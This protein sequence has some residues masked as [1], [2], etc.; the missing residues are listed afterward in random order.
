MQKYKSFSGE[1]FTGIKTEERM[2]MDKK[3]SI[4]KKYRSIFAG[5]DI[6]SILKPKRQEF[7][8]LSWKTL[9]SAEESIKQ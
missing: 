8:N 2:D 5:K 4:L 6:P 7:L 1:R 3:L 9:E